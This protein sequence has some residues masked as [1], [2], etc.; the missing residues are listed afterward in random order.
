MSTEVGFY[1]LNRENL[2]EGLLKGEYFSCNVCG[3]PFPAVWI[4]FA[5]V[6]DDD[7]KLDANITFLIY[8][9]LVA[10]VYASILAS[11]DLG[12]VAC[13]LHFG[14][15]Y[16][17][18]MFHPE[19]FWRKIKLRLLVKLNGGLTVWCENYS[20]IL[21]QRTFQFSSFSNLFINTTPYTRGQLRI[22]NS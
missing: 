1:A 11:W 18:V 12:A 5:F 8:L 9:W 14:E 13:F 10:V 4:D 16:I 17:F 3:V 20:S 15:E 2:K 22:S 19:K 21:W 7:A 6:W